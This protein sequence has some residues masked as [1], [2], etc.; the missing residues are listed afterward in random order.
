MNTANTTK[1]LEDILGDVWDIRDLIER[2]E[3]IETALLECFNEQQE[4]E[5]DDTTTDNPEDSAFLAWAT[6]T[7]HDDAEEFLQIKTILEEL[8]GSGGDEQFRGDW[9]PVTMIAE[10]YFTEYCEEFL[11]DCDMLPRDIASFIEID[12]EGTASNM[13]MDYSEIEI[14]GTTYYYR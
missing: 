9:Y 6:Q 5:G 12:W 3:E 7:T 2:L 8:N 11:K 13:K 1:T 14:N 4:I 10:D